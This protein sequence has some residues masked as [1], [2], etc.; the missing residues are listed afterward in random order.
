L[1]RSS[2]NPGHTF[3]LGSCSL[4]RF[5]EGQTYPVAIYDPRVSGGANLALGF[6]AMCMLCV[7]QKMWK[8][9]F[10]PLA[11]PFSTIARR[12]RFRMVFDDEHSV[13]LDYLAFYCTTQAF[14]PGKYLE[15][16]IL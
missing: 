3:Y 13:E 2:G 11:W 16:K 15:L 6:P 14:E 4:G 7:P 9:Y 8:I 12:R 5:W 10:C 1:R